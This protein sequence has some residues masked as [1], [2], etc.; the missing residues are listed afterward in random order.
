MGNTDGQV[1]GAQDAQNSESIAVGAGADNQFLGEAR[2][3]TEKSKDKTTV[4]ICEPSIG[5]INFKAHEAMCDVI[6][7]VKDYEHVSNYKFFKSCLG[8]LMV[9]YSREKFAEYAVNA[10]FDYIMFMDDDHVWPKDI[11]QR[12]E[13]HIKEYDIVAPLCVQRAYPYYPVIYKSEFKQQGDKIAWN[14]T[15][16]V[17][18]KDINRGDLVTDADAI[19]FGCANIKVELF[20]KVPRPWFFSMVP[21]GEDILFCMRAKQTVQAKILVDTNVEAPHLKDME[22]AMFD[23]YLRC[24]AEM[25][26]KNDK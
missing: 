5:T 20:K 23:D 11:F 7:S 15:K 9:A 18:L 13:K 4:L 14:N 22:V 1:P 12:L 8:K 17:E 6:A 10:G 16:Y 26:R 2:A 21:I 19:G 24:K 3:F 25:E